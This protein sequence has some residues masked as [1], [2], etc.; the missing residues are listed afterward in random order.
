MKDIKCD[1]GCCTLCVEPYEE[2]N[3]VYKNIPRKKSGI[4]YLDRRKNK[5]LLVQSRGNLWGF[6]K[7]TVKENEEFQECAIREFFEETGIKVCVE[8]LKKAP[9]F[10]VNE[11]VKYYLLFGTEKKMEVQNRIEDND[12]NGIGWLRATCCK[13]MIESKSSTFS[14]THHLKII[15]KKLNL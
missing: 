3:K 4:I 6:P 1:N 7:G 8:K 12:A 14:F 9:S 2:K 5:I 11:S 10:Y 15:L 13:S